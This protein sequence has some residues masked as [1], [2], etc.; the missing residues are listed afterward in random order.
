MA[1]LNPEMGIA[2]TDTLAQLSDVLK[3][4]TPA[5]ETEGKSM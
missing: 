1:A 4:V 5:T 2:G 3:E